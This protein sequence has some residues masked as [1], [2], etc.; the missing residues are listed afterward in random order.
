MD[1]KER[2]LLYLQN[3]DVCLQDNFEYSEAISVLRKS[4]YKLAYSGRKF[5][6]N[7]IKTLVGINKEN[8]VPIEQRRKN[9][10]WNARKIFIK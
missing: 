10:L 8:Q 7:G 5:S 6:S 2:T 4:G 1:T 3:G 9:G